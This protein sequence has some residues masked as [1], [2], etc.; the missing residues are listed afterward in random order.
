M[1]ILSKDI[2]LNSYVIYE[3]EYNMVTAVEYCL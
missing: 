1:Q 2:G 3:N